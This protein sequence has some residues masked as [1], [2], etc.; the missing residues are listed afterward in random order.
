MASGLGERVVRLRRLVEHARDLTHAAH[1]SSDEAHRKALLAELERTQGDVLLSVG[2][3]EALQRDLSA[4]SP[5]RRPPTLDLS[6]AVDST[7]RLIRTQLAP[8][9]RLTVQVDATPQVRIDPGDLAQVLS[10]LLTNAAQAVQE[11]DRGEIRVVVDEDDGWARVRVEDTGHGISPEVLPRIF[12]PQFTTRPGAAG[13]GLAI[14]R[15]LAEASGG[16]LE[17]ERPAVGAAFRLELPRS[18]AVEESGEYV[19]G[20]GLP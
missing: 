19:R 16:Q 8:T 9:T 6:R 3:L 15:H 5:A 4:L 10:H 17:A 12:D 1:R 2:E 18:D 11:L 20:G 14:S 13:L 7:V